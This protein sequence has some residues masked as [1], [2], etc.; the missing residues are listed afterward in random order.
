MSRFRLHSGFTLVELLVVIAIIGILIALLLP[1]VQSARET[2]RRTQCTN[3]LKQIGLAIQNHIA[4]FE[5]FPTGGGN[6]GARRT[7]ANGVPAGFDKQEWSWGYQILPLLELQTLYDLPDDDLVAMTPV[8]T[9]F[10]PS[11]RSPVALSGGPWQSRPRPRAM[12]DYAGNAGVSTAQG[13]RSSGR[14][15]NGEDGIIRFY[16]LGPVPIATVHDGMSNTFLIGEKRLNF[17][18]AETECGPGDNDGYVGGYQDDVVRWGSVLPEID[19]RGPHI[20]FA[21]LYPFNFQ[22]GASH[23][24]VFMMVFCDGSVRPINYSVDKETFSSLSG[25]KDRKIVSAEDL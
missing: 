12:L 4:T 15:G 22:F 7:K 2:A 1:A 17:Y 13:S 11:R 5:E 21:N 14:L 24:G 25:R 10:C 6:Y 8:E 16:K 23:P 19:Y 9:F 20:T 3:H 18:V